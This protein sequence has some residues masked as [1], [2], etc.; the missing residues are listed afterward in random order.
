MCSIEGCDA[1]PVAHGLC[2]KHYMRR[3]RTGDPGKVG[4]AGRPR[5]PDLAESAETY[6]SRRSA[7]RVKQGVRWLKYAGA[8]SYAILKVFGEATRPSTKVVDVKNPGLNISKFR[9]LA[10]AYWCAQPKNPA[11]PRTSA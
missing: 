11:K 7:F 1:N 4:K 5:D 6:G 8:D 9:H 10:A 2:A 3:R